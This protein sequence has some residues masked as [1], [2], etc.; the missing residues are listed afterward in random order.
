MLHG[1]VGL[2]DEAGRVCDHQ[3]G[4]QPS[5]H[6]LPRRDAI[7][8][9][10]ELSRFWNARWLCAEL[11][12]ISRLHPVASRYRTQILLRNSS[13]HTCDRAITRLLVCLAP[14]VRYSIVAWG[15]PRK[16]SGLK[17]RFIAA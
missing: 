4:T 6:H 10:P 11:S 1:P 3:Q 7:F 13:R 9:A 15:Q 5:F 12:G 8:H 17:A 2:L 14:K 16:L